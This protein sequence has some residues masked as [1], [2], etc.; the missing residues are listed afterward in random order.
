ML[1]VGLG[2]LPQTMV[3]TEPGFDARQAA[4][5]VL[6]DVAAETGVLGAVWLSRADRGSVDRHRRS[7]ARWTPEL[8]A[9]SGLLAAVTTV[10]FFDHYTWTTPAG[11]IWVAIAL[12]LWAGAYQATVA[13]EDRA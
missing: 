10:G 11:L 8:V 9:A 7:R 4:H 12:G 5:V 3:V 1:G 2:M 6:L 13:E